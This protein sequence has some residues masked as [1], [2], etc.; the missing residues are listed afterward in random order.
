MAYDLC[1]APPGSDFDT[2]WTLVMKFNAYFYLILSILVGLMVLGTCCLP[3][4]FCGCCGMIF[5][6]LAHLAALIITGVFRFNS[7]G[8][9]CAKNNAPVNGDETFAEHGELIQNL[10]IS[11]CALFMV[12]GV[13][14]NCIMVFSGYTAF[15]TC[16]VCFGMFK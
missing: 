9:D 2:Q 11:Q 6:G 4:W 3:F 1:G 16:A 13:M 10:F 8:S 5:A 14:A 15:G 7:N 12:H